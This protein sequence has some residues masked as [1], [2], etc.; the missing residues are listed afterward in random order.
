MNGAISVHASNVPVAATSTTAYYCTSTNLKYTVNPTSGGSG[1]K[2]VT[3]TVSN[4][5]GT[6]LPISAVI[7][8]WAG[9][10]NGNS[11]FH[12]NGVAV[13]NST[14]TLGRIQENLH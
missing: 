12:L 2:I 5:V 13:T 9:S 6:P 1:N 14:L 11:D 7:I 10:G 3:W 8:S 4:T